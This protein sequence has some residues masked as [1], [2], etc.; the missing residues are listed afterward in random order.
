MGQQMS[1]VYSGMFY[2]AAKTRDYCGR[3]K[4]SAAEYHMFANETHNAFNDFVE[5]ES[6]HGTTATEMKL[7]LAGGAGKML[8]EITDMNK[9]MADDQD[10]MISA[11]EEMVD[12]SP[13]AR[14]E[15]DTLDIIGEDFRGFYGIY[16]DITENVR[17]IVSELMGEFGS[18]KEFKQPDGQSGLNEFIG[19]CG[20]E[21]KSAGYI[22]ECQDKLVE[23]DETVS[24]T[25]KERDTIEHTQSLD[26]RFTEISGVLAEFSPENDIKTE[27]QEVASITNLNFMIGPDASESAV[28]SSSTYTLH[29]LSASGTKAASPAGMMGVGMYPGGPGIPAIDPT[30]LI[31]I[32]KEAGVKVKDLIYF[33]LHKHI[34]Q[35]WSNQKLLIVLYLLSQITLV[36][37]EV[38]ESHQTHNK[39]VLANDET[40]YKPGTFIENQNAWTQIYYGHTF[41][42]DSGTMAYSGCEIIAVINAYTAMGK[43]L[44]TDE[45]AE[46]ITHFEMRG[47]TFCGT[48]GTSPTVLVEYLTAQGY[49]TDICQSEDYTEIQRI[50]DN[51]DTLIVTVYNNEDDLFGMIHTV[52]VQK[53]EQPDGSYKYVVHNGHGPVQYDTVE[54]AIEH[55]GNEGQT[56]V[57]QVIGVSEPTP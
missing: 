31:N 39:Q 57:I 22:S 41:W 23:F 6:F 40:L 45:V 48:F 55:I 33:L 13:N 28:F 38:A 25:L 56:G 35:D 51:S 49:E 17:S 19:F 54:D 43:D 3:M 21:S 53:V 9:Q 18:Y 12:A 47:A 14:I 27:N 32:A 37:Y 42:E 50:A 24:G 46:L 7:F 30:V 52:N 8:T 1:G 26:N 10:Y 36:P 44:T 11:F 16:K 15:Y 34:P 29:N 20:G 4:N 2:D 5:D